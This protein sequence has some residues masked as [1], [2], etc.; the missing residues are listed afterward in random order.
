MAF[1][2]TNLNYGVISRT[3]HWLTAFI[4][5]SSIGL[6][7]FMV[8]LDDSDLKQDLYSLHKSLGVVILGLIFIRLLWL[9]ISPNPEKLS[10][11]KFEYRLSLV[12]KGILY[13]SLLGMPISGWILSNSAG[14]DVAFFGLFVL[15]SL[16]GE[17]EMID[18]VV[19]DIHEIFGFILIGVILLHIAGALKHH[20]VYKD[21]TLLRMLG[22]NKESK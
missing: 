15:P 8:D 11:N 13:F 2:N 7:L 4:F 10:T 5:I 16:V 14:Y 20:F 17:S 19:R 12:V 18:E 22:Q 6:G 1:K 21:G 9:K 3:I